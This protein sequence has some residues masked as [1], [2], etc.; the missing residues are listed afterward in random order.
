M[1]KKGIIQSLRTRLNT[2]IHRLHINRK[3]KDR[4]FC[5]LFSEDKQALLQLYNALH[6]TA[7][8]DPVQLTVVTLDNIIYM[9]MVNDL[10][11]VIAGVLNLYEHQSTYN[12]NMPLRFLLYIAEEYDKIIHRQD[13]DI[14][15]SKLVMLPTPQCVVFYNGGR[16]TE[17]EEVLRLSDA[18][19]NKDILSDLELTVH[20]RN[21]NLGHNEALMNQCHK[22]WEYA[23][24]VSR[25]NENLAGGMAK[26]IAVEEAVTYCLDRG[27]LADFL[28]SNRSGVLGMLRLL[29]EY[30]EKEHMR[31]VKRDARQEGEVIGEL[32]RSREVIYDFLGRLG[33]I[34]MDIY[35]CV[36]A[37][38]DVGT[39]RQWYIAAPQVES[40]DAFRKKIEA[41]ME[42]VDKV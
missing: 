28:K 12:P 23:S 11:F 33:E 25:V 32:K 1:G 16:E 22:L 24:L 5:A 19:Q 7:Y 3:Y 18:F 8:T 38:E 39:L 4:L 29:T 14:Y 20:L 40:F 6:G 2:Y 21:I 41:P 34:P 17:D 13:V 35:K 36:E 37:Q 10:A 42:G 26:E 30:D 15:G 27:I 9:K 31:R